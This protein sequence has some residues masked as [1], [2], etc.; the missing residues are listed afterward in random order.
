MPL[1]LR[2]VREGG[3]TVTAKELRKFCKSCPVRRYYLKT[4]RCFKKYLARPDWVESGTPKE[5]FRNST[6]AVADNPSRLVYCEGLGWP[7]GEDS[8]YEHA[9]V[10]NLD[11]EVID[12]T[13]HDLLP[14]RKLRYWGIPF[15]WDFVRETCLT[16]NKFGVV[17]VW[18]EDFPL[19]NG[20]IPAEEYLWTPTAAGVEA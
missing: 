17:N 12:P 19:L 2:W 3:K 6:L 16:H 8:P 4:G 13:W 7:E 10:I 5:C 9:W 14:N 15:K 1:D 20:R 11:E 18:E